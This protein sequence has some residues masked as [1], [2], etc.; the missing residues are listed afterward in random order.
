MTTKQKYMGKPQ[1]KTDLIASARREGVVASEESKHLVE[2]FASVKERMS[3]P[4]LD[5][6]TIRDIV[7]K[8]PTVAPCKDPATRI[9]PQG[10]KRNQLHIC[11]M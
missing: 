9:G 8:E 10:F 6:A 3:K 2:L 11:H 7:E 1:G 4:N 5:L